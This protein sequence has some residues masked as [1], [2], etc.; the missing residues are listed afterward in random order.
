GDRHLGA[1]LTK[2]TNLP[3]GDQYN[4]VRM[5]L[6]DTEKVLPGS[7]TLLIWHSEFLLQWAVHFSSEELISSAFARSMLVA[8]TCCR[9]EKD[10]VV[11]APLEVMS[12]YSSRP[13][14]LRPITVWF[15]VCS[16]S[17]ASLTSEEASVSREHPTSKMQSNAPS[18][19]P[20]KEKLQHLS[21]AVATI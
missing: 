5:S 4:G 14:S 19:A 3:S 16:S 8:V 18:M 21:R 15:A 9:S 1:C 6:R 13:P 10:T 20:S 7:P 12:R 11:I 2:K 17:T